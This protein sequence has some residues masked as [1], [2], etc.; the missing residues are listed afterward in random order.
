MLPRLGEHFEAGNSLYLALDYLE[1]QTLDAMI[2]GGTACASEKIALVWAAEL[3]DALA[4]LH[5]PDADGLRFIYA[6]LKP[7]NIIR[8]ADGRLFLVDFGSAR[9]LQTGVVEALS[10][11]LGTPGFAAPEQGQRV[12]ERTDV[13]GLGATLVYLL[14]GRT[15]DHFPPGTPL[16]GPQG[17]ISPAVMA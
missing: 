10:L 5:Q 13:F 8:V 11:R 17:T 9:A 3:A 1:G 4:T 2:A 14:T 7:E 12:S 6:D 16:S 15:I